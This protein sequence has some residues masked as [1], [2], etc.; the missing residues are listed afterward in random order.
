MADTGPTPFDLLD[1]VTEVRVK[2]N[3]V[4]MGVLRIALEHAP[5]E[6]IPLI[7]TII[8][9]DRVISDLMVSMADAAENTHKAL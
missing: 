2:N 1:S 8:Q 7:R 6:T 3:N 9:N 4:W 5:G